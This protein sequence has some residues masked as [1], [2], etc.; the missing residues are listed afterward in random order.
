MRNATAAGLLGTT[1][2]VGNGGRGIVTD[3][4]VDAQRVP[5]L[6]RLLMSDSGMLAYVSPAALETR[7]REGPSSSPFALMT[8]N[9]AAFY[10]GR[11]L[12]WLA[13][14]TFPRRPGRVS[15]TPR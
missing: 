12:R 9:E 14:R 2:L 3:V 7:A 6:L 5:V 13:A 4:L 10:E 8:E 15:S 11:G 1:V